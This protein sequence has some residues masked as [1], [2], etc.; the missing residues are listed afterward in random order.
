MDGEKAIRS[1]IVTGQNGNA[2]RVMQYAAVDDG[3]VTPAWITGCLDRG[4]TVVEE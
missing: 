4:F 3:G 2:V 1:Y